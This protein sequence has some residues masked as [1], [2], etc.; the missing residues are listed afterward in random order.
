MF[1][2]RHRGIRSIIV[3]PT[4]LIISDRSRGG[5]VVA[6]ITV[7]M[8]NG[9]PFRGFIVVRSHLFVATRYYTMSQLVLARDLASTD[10][11]QSGSVTITAVTADSQ[12]T[13]TQ[14]IPFTIAPPMPAE[15]PPIFAGWPASMALADNMKAGAVAA[16][17]TLTN[18]DGSP[19]NGTVTVSGSDLFSFVQ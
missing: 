7:Q 14:V 19:F 12:F 15:G 13:A 2:R 4:P 1:F 10:D 9:T 18:S 16:S 6:H 3:T 5:S 8:A 11:T 17:G